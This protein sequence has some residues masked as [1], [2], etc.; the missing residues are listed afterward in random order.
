M[1]KIIVKKFGGTS[2]A[3][4]INIKNVA[5]H[6][7]YAAGNGELVVA[8]VSAMAGTT[9]SLISKCLS[10]SK[11]DRSELLKEYDTTISSG[12][13]ITAS[14]LAL[15][16]IEMG[17]KSKSL[18]GWQIPILTNQN[19]SN[20]LIENIDSGHII[21][22]L[23]QDTIPVITGFQGVTNNNEITTL[24]KGGSDTTASLVAA[25]IAAD[26]CDIY[27]D[28]DGVY[29]ADPRIIENAIKLDNLTLRQML[30]LSHL[31]AKVLHPRAA[32]ACLRY[33][34]DM[35][36]L[37]S[38]REPD[39]KDN[40]TI[41]EKCNIEDYIDAQ[42]TSEKQNRIIQ[43]RIIQNGEI[44]EN[45]QVKAITANRNILKIKI[46]FL[47]E[48]DKLTSQPVE[49][50]KM[51]Y[52]RAQS[53]IDKVNESGLSFSS[54]SW[55]GGNDG[56]NAELSMITNLIEQNRYEALLLSLKSNH[57]INNYEFISSLATISLI[58]YGINNNELAGQAIS[59]LN[60]AKI[61]IYSLK[62]GDIY[63]TFTINDVDADK[64]IKALHV[65]ATLE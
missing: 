19:F 18:Q 6:I 17:F 37:S 52:T 38:F 39:D 8:V 50:W 29:S 4:T 51:Q 15:E 5:K 2:V 58:G 60:D 3:G 12:E 24:G 35:C 22:L 30:A 32:L 44:M 46:D 28:V 47:N 63:M 11:L 55:G 13:I 25:A 9:N 23:E 41:I 64:A 36:I 49:I 16:L 62:T 7:A 56:K 27:T 20:A 40:G 59:I 26:R 45:S 42:V 48:E 43:N 61:V 10:I 57:L 21:S 33:N 54:Y 34:I 31:G 1:K 14:L 53:F 65:L